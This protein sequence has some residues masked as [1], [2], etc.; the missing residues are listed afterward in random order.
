QASA[1]YG[2]RNTEGGATAPRDRLYTASLGYT[3]DSG[4]S[5]TAGWARQRI[6]GATTD[7]IGAIVGYTAKF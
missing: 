4:I 3:F 6:A 5:L 2:L 1:V 7:T